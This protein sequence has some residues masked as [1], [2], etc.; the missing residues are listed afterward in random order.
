M[1]QPRDGFE[2]YDVA[3]FI[4]LENCLMHVLGKF[5]CDMSQN[6]IFS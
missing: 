4:D 1:S 6:V 3:S 5:V 2:K